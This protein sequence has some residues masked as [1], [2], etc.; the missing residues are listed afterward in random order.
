M[1][2]EQRYGDILNTDTKYIAHCVN[3]Q[4]KMASGV[5]RAIR[6]RYPKAY[7]DYMEV[8]HNSGLPL[9]KVIASVNKPHTVLHI[10]GQQTYGYDGRTYVN[11]RALRRGIRTINKNFNEPVSFPLI[12]CG[13]AGGD[14][15]I[16]RSIIEE[17]STNF[18]PVVYVL[19]DE[20]PF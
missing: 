16:V 15:S 10:V 17:E 5:A 9:G 7:S 18:Q 14:W 11:Y 6:N 20:I 1:I 4:G 3:A 8:F 13:L 19:N 2:I 12:G